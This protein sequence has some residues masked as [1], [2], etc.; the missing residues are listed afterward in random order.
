[1]SE[2]QECSQF[3]LRGNSL[4]WHYYS[5]FSPQGMFFRHVAGGRWVVGRLVF[6]TLLSP[7]FVMGK[8][9]FLPE[10]HEDFES[11]AWE[12]LDT[13]HF[14]HGKSLPT[15]GFL[16][17]KFFYC[18][19]EDFFPLMLS[20]SL[21]LNNLLEMLREGLPLSIGVGRSLLKNIEF[22]FRSSTAPLKKISNSYTP[23]KQD[24][25]QNWIQS[26]TL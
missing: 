6:A 23:M 12:S 7:R 4:P 2:F 13:L 21:S 24:K 3:I 1:M 15:T 10:S 18:I 14:E 8:R 16:K 19:R 17:V 5:L 26:V 9:K 22:A 20:Q 25:T 11:V